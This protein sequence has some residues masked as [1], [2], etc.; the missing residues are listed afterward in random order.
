[1][2]R[3]L[4]RRRKAPATA[5]RALGLPECGLSSCVRGS[6]NFTGASSDVPLGRD[7]DYFVII[8]DALCNG[9][10]I[11]PSNSERQPLDDDA[12]L[13]VF[14]N[15]CGHDIRGCMTRRERSLARE[16]LRP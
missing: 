4:L 12:T 5:N 13:N 6:D 7:Y 2:N 16:F 10:S 3:S 11:S 1:L 8:V 9:I 15:D 14:Q